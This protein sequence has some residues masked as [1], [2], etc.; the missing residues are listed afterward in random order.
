MFDRY[1][2]IMT[3]KQFFK[4][5]VSYNKKVTNYNFV[6]S[7]VWFLKVELKEF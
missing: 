3:N 1:D 2:D 5:V 6:T 4:M 7:K